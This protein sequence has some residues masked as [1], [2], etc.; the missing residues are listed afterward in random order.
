LRDSKAGKWLGVIV[1]HRGANVFANITPQMPFFEYWFC[2]WVAGNEGQN[3][4]SVR[5]YFRF[6]FLGVVFSNYHFCSKI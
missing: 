6:E 1:N 5:R 2:I 4:V 3:E